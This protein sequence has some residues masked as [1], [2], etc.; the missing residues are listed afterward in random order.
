MLTAAGNA[1]SRVDWASVPIH[2][3]L[4]AAVPVLFLFAENVEQ[5]LTLAPLWA[6]LGLCLAIGAGTLLGCAVL[7]RSWHRGAVLASWLLILF[8]S[9]GHVWQSVASFLPGAWVVAVVW[10]VLA[11]A[12]LA[13]IWLARH[14][15]GGRWAV[16]ASSFLNLAALL[17][18]ALNGYRVATYAWQPLTAQAVT[19]TEEVVLHAPAEMPDIY[20][21]ILDRYA[22]SVT[23]TSHYGFD[24]EP[25]LGE[26]ERRGF[27]VA[28]DSRANYFKTALS[29]A[30]SLSMDYLD[31][32]RLRGEP[33]AE[34]SKV[35]AALGD[36]LAVP[37]AL[38]RLGYGYVHIGN[39][40][41]P[42][43]RNVD[44]D[45][46]LR[47]QEYAEFSSALWAT[48]L[49]TFF[50]SEAEQM[51][52]NDD[53]TTA[54]YDLARSTTLY[55]FERLEESTER[56]GPTFVF[57]HLLV[58]HTPYV[59]DADGSLPTPEEARKRG[60]DEE[61]LAQLAW[62][63]QRVLEAIDRILEADAETEPIIV[64]QAD[65]GPY[66]YRFR[67]IEG[68]FQ[69]FGATDEEIQQKFGI[70]NAVRYPSVDPAAHGFHE[71]VSPVNQFRILFNAYFD[72][73]LSLLPDV[74]Y[75]SRDVTH[76]W[77]LRSYPWD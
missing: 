11:L 12:G 68:P 62:T 8:F 75:L 45:V 40:W 66:P 61:Y 69:W 31:T 59:F 17:L 14:W 23:L 5:Q 32:T 39:Y 38:K 35:L 47:F 53:E 21:I 27:S 48:T 2:P 30:S 37:A 50:A 44:A 49:M 13:F 3:V 7:L 58:P 25:F 10:F 33:G 41:E 43:A 26:I 70:L 29:L 6:P 19:G 67:V 36:H 73:G 22:S 76:W 63:N 77:D 71:S 9:F 72:A 64:L 65:E 20:Y 74:T 52:V 34:W 28:R 4:V 15:R 16:T 18:I 42:T 60:E 57:A 51:A 54:A 56:S 55:A 1:R 46:T 24:N